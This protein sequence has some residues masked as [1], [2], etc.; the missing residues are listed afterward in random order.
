MSSSWRWLLLAFVR[1]TM[2]RPISDD[3]IAGS[4][5]RGILEVAAQATCPGSLPD[6]CPSGYSTHDI[7][8]VGGCIGIQQCPPGTEKA[9]GK[10]FK[11]C[12]GGY[13]AVAWIYCVKPGT[14][15]TA[16]VP[17]TYH[18]PHVPA[19]APPMTG[20]KCKPGT[21]LAGVKMIGIS[22]GYCYETSCYDKTLSGQA[23]N[24]INSLGTLFTDSYANAAK[25][26]AFGKCVVTNLENVKSESGAAWKGFEGSLK[27][28][29]S[30][31]TGFIE[32]STNAYHSLL[33]PIAKNVLGDTETLC[34][35]PRGRP[36]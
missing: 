4:V 29:F 10:C 36:S 16:F 32:E 22:A 1:L 33:E 14:W 2:A 19:T 13:K 11:L 8:G 12:K 27:T 15:R 26:E 5:E 28:L 20:L 34:A 3:A 7:L 35:L 9:F 6:W 21:K 23:T 24:V 31:R 25:I 30:S 18:R 17:S